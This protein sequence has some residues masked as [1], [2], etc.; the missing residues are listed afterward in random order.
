M[1]EVGLMQTAL[2]MAFEQ[3][4]NAGASRIHLVRLRVG[5]LSGVVPDALRMAFAAAIPGTAAAE[6]T[7]IVEEIPVRCRCQGC[8][9]E[10]CPDDVVYLC[11]NCDTINSCI[12]TGRELELASLEVS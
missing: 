11:S 12:E 3:T 7:L 1:H 10:Y 6:A 5:A 9:Q 8:G 2:D 4:R